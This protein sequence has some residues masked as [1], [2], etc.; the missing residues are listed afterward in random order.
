MPEEF[1]IQSSQ[2]PYNMALWCNEKTKCITAD[3]AHIIDILNSNNDI[4]ESTKQL[5]KEYLYSMSIDATKIL[6]FSC[7]EIWAHN[8][9]DLIFDNGY[10]GYEQVLANYK[11]L[12]V[13]PNQK[14]KEEITEFLNKF[15]QAITGERYNSTLIHELLV[16]YDIKNQLIDNITCKIEEVTNGQETWEN[17]VKFSNEI[18]PELE[19]LCR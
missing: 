6:A 3:I 18:M 1:L 9:A 5:I 16:Q 8:D 2:F 12:K 15:R 13:T 10:N 19:N 17:F 4:S 7:G 11:L 14:R